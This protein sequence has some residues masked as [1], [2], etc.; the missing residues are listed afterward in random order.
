MST[1]TSTISNEKGIFAFIKRNPL[2]SM[3]IIMF[4][5]AWSVMIPQA[6]YSQGVLSAPLPEFIEILTGWVPGIAAVIV[7]AVIA[8]RAGIRDLLR[9]FLIWRV[10]LRWYLVSTFLLAALILG[11]IGL[12]VSFGG[13][14]PVIP[15]AE[16]PL[17]QVAL[18]FLV[19]VLLGALIN[20]EEI[21][22]RGFALPRL[23]ARHGALIAG[24]FIAIPEVLFHLPVFWVNEN[25]FFQ[26]VGIYWFSA[27]SVAA[28][29]I[30]I[31]VFNKTKGSLLI[32]TLLHASQNA[33]ANLLSD[34]SVR[35]FQFTVAL[36][37][38]IALALIVSTRG[39]LGYRQDSEG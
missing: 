29:I 5:V 18:V 7:S 26:T 22:W 33:W 1:L 10:G 38:L 17:W 34:N 8:G 37:W 13:A 28:V 12:H 24:L 36:A 3:Y 11:G 20:T 15:A 35:P 21:A 25:P 31:F 2:T 9:R 27:F 23:Q 39:K 14:M 4:S 16:S 6:L 30:Y 19:F 32:V